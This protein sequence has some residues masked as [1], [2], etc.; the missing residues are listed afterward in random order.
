MQVAKPS[1][2]E[3]SWQLAVVVAKAELWHANLKG[4]GK[5]K[6]FV[7]A[8]ANGCV[9]TTKQAGSPVA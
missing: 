5:V 7:S 6:C 8:R 4:G 3:K 1:K 9:L 2:I